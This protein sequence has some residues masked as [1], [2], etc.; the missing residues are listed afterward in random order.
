MKVCPVTHVIYDPLNLGIICKN[1]YVSVTNDV[2]DVI[3]VNNEK[4]WG[5]HSALWNTSI[6]LGSACLETLDQLL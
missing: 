5:Q 4:K 2:S 3:D 1:S 6:D